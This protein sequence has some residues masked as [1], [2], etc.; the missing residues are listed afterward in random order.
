MQRLRQ[1][2][3]AFVF[4]FGLALAA[5]PGA[6]A[7]GFEVSLGLEPDGPT[8]EYDGVDLDAGFYL[9]FGGRF[10]ERWS[11]EIR[12]LDQDGRRI[13]LTSWQLGA[14]YALP[15]GSEWKPFVQAG[16][17]FGDLEARNEVVCSRRGIR[18]PC[19]ALR[20]S[21]EDVGIYAGG[22]VD[23]NFAPQFALRF[24]GRLLVFDS[25]LTDDLETEAD[26]TAGVVFRF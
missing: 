9:G 14:R 3:Y 26:V 25:E 23:W 13:D 16:A 22:G 19:P 5:A 10:D 15:S 11:G 21:F 1:A 18:G 4:A 24:D 7:E 20:E 2:P 12:V 17:H 6:R 8:S